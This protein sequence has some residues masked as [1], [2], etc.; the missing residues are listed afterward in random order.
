[1]ALIACQTLERFSSALMQAAGASPDEAATVARHVVD[2]N[3]AGMGEG[4]ESVRTGE[5]TQ[6]IRES[7]TEAGAVTAGDWIGLMRGDGVVSVGSTMERASIVLL[8]RLVDDGAEIVTVITGA[9]ADAATTSAI[10]GW[11]GDSRADVAVE[12]HPGGQPLYPYLF[13]VE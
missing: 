9:E 7:N 10:E 3:L 12:I 8:E 5:V 1:M 6:A 2:A 4:A 11:L 13:G